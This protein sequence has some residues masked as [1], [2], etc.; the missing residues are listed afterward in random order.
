MAPIKNMLA[1]LVAGTVVA[2]CNSVDTKTPDSVAPSAVLTTYVDIAQ[3]NY[4]DSL[5]TAQ[6]LNESIAQLLSEP[7]EENLDGAKAAWVAARVPYQ[8]TE[9]YRFGNASVDDWEGKVNAWPLDEGLIDYV[10]PAYGTESDENGF[11]TA[12][13]IANPT[14]TIGGVT[15]DAS[16]ID[17]ALLSDTLHE[18]DEIES[19]V[20]TGYHVIEFLLWG[21]D[22]NGT[23]PGAGARPATDYSLENCT[24]GNCDRRRAY[25]QAATELLI[26]DLQDM[27]DSWKEGGAAQ[28]ALAAK[29]AEG[30]LTTILTGMGSLAY[31]ELAGERIKLGLM[32]HDPEEEHDCFSD[33]THWSHFY[34]AK[35]IKNAYLGEYTRVD[36][37]V[38]SGQSL[39]DLVKSTDAALDAEMK[40]KLNATE[41]AMQAMVD[42][43]A[44]GRTFDVL[45]GANETAGNQVIQNVVDALVAQTKTTEKIIVALKLNGIELEGSDSLD[46]PSSIAH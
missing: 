15:V 10:A 17:K 6:A 44:K 37:S 23:N 33:N 28:Q 46:N 13:I 41:S 26:D 29:G 31:G 11:Y 21:Q 40:E 9:V 20:A 5:I 30:G 3:A 19:N 42:E 12:N 1:V 22:L 2:G 4:A 8:Q 38:V 14:L 34:D 36:G 27:A 16:T 35:G 24:G 32:L 25:L 45:I 7:T 18:I 43:A 39:S